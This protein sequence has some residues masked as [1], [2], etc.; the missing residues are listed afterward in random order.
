MGV[1]W[2]HINVFENVK[3]KNHKTDIEEGYVVATNSGQMAVVPAWRIMDLLNE[4]SLAAQRRA[5]E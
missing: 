5:L 2:G 3:H 4:E 1:D